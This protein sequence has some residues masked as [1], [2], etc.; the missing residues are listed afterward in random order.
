M[1]ADIAENGY[2]L[3]RR[4]EITKPTDEARRQNGSWVIN[5]GDEFRDLQPDYLFV[6]RKRTELPFAL[7]RSGTEMPALPPCA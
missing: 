5:I 2:R 3:L 6:R 1:Q 7:V 4:G